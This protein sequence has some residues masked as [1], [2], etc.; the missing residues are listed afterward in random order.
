MPVRTVLVVTTVGREHAVIPS[1][2]ETGGVSTPGAIID[3]VGAA[4]EMSG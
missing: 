4:W 2:R 3:G 1:H